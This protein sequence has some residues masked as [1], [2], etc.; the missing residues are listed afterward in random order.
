MSSR[1]VFKHFKHAA[2]VALSR[3]DVRT[4]LLGAIGIR[5]DGAIVKARNESTTVPQKT[6]HAEARLA[7]RLNVGSIVYVARVS[8]LNGNYCMSRPCNNCMRLLQNRGVKTIYYTISQ[9]EYGVIELAP[10]AR[11]IVREAVKA[12]I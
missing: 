9:S 2:S 3:D 7:K 1:D 12:V 8:R 10:P 11:A 5:G 4:F 6:A